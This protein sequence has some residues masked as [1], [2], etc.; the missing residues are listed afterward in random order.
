MLP[1]SAVR[2]IRILEMV[3]TMR[4]VIE[5]HRMRKELAHGILCCIAFQWLIRCVAK[6]SVEEEQL[7]HGMGG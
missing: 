6:Q 1:L 3:K 5:R 2:T 4:H 7:W